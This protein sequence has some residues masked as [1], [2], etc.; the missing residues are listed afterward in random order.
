[1]LLKWK[2]LHWQPPFTLIQDLREVQ[3]GGIITSSIAS[4]ACCILYIPVIVSSLGQGLSVNCMS[5]QYSVALFTGGSLSE[6]PQHHKYDSPRLLWHCGFLS[7]TASLLLSFRMSFFCGH[8]PQTHLQAPLLH[9]LGSVSKMSCN[10][11]SAASVQAV[12]FMDSWIKKITI[13]FWH[14]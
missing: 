12:Q 4:S 14:L 10:C 3:W 1:M 13:H 11:A 7:S 2:H 9:Y 8:P 5:V 6:I